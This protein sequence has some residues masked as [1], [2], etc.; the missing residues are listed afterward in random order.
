MKLE[1]IKVNYPKFHEKIMQ[2]SKNWK[3]GV[4]WKGKDKNER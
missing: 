4:F 1:R 2:T 3:E